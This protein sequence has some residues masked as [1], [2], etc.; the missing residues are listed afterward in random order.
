MQRNSNTVYMQRHRQRAKLG[1]RVFTITL[2]DDVIQELINGGALLEFNANNPHS[3]NTA[4]QAVVHQYF[5][6]SIPADEDYKP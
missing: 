5:F 3:V 4:L 6:G 1:L 2:P